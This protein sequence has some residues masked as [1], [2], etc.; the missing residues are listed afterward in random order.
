MNSVKQ[1]HSK[2]LKT[3]SEELFNE[4]QSLRKKL[5]EKEAMENYFNEFYQSNTS[6]KNQ[7]INVMLF[8]MIINYRQK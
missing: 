1:N 7:L 8:T 4:V 3:K 6:N 2:E 5:E